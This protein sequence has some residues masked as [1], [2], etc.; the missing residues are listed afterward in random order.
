MVES[1][2][3]PFVPLSESPGFTAVEGC[4]DW[5]GKKDH[6]FG[7]HVRG[8]VPEFGQTVDLGGSLLE[9]EF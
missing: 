5:D 4:V 7:L 3:L 6:S 1:G 2:E 8:G 9:A